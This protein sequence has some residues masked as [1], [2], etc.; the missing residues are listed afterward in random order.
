MMV[1]ISKYVCRTLCVRCVVVDDKIMIVL[2]QTKRGA[3]E[4]SS[5]PRSTGYG[6]MKVEVQLT[7]LQP[8][9]AEWWLVCGVLSPIC[10]NITPKVCAGQEWSEGH[11][12]KSKNPL[13]PSERSYCS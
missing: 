8:F 10:K 9:A 6:G 7:G 3:Y 5:I 13:Q 12:K 11:Q 4:A 2:K 1:H